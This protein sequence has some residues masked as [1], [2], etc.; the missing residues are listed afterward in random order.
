MLDYIILAIAVLVGVSLLWTIVRKLAVK[1]SMVLINSIVG[2]A[3]LFGLNMFVGWN[4]PLTIPVIVVCG[5]FGLPGVGAI[6]LLYF[7]NII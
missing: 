3:V 1:A 6:V 7:F 5:L 2:L 4:I